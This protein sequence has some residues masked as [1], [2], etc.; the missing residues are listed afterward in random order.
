MIIGREIVLKYNGVKLVLD[1]F[2]TVLSEYSLDIQ[3]VVRSAILDDVDISGYIQMYSSSPYQLDLVR[4]MLKEGI[5]KKY[6]GVY[7]EKGK[8]Y[9]R[10]LHS[11]GYSLEKLGNK[12]NL[13]SL[14]ESHLEYLYYWVSS[15][16]DVSY[17]NLSIIP[18]ELLPQFDYGIK[19]GLSMR[20]YNNGVNYSKEYMYACMRIQKSGKSVSGILGKDLDIDIV[21]V[22]ENYTSMRSDIFNKVLS[23]TNNDSIP[24]RVNTLCKLLTVRPDLLDVLLSSKHDKC[25]DVHC[26]KLLLEAHRSG[27][28]IDELLKYTDYKSIEN[29]YRVLLKRN[30]G[31]K[32]V[33]TKS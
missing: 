21:K 33:V 30:K 6:V 25:Y 7:G 4:L 16:Y 32:G 19:L 12:N 24:E 26:L 2:R 31:I 29:Q 9:I 10:K 11:A 1:N 17:L 20:P 23:H 18:V 13:S 5:P 8:L 3:D 22:L 27:V 28:C 15:G 14:S